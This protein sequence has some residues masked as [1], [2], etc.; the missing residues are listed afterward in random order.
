MP[1][2]TP[3]DYRPL[4][5]P[6]TRELAFATLRKAFERR[7]E[8]SHLRHV[9]PPVAVRASGE[10]GEVAFACCGVDGML[11][12]PSDLEQWKRSRMEAY[13][14]GA[15]YGL[16]TYTIL[17]DTTACPDNVEGP[18]SDRWHCIRSI[19][20]EQENSATLTESMR[21]I[22][23]AVLDAQKEIFKQFPHIPATLP[24]E[25]H[26]VSASGIDSLAHEVRAYGAVSVLDP[27][28]LAAD[29]YLW[30]EI[31]GRE[32]HFAE[33][34]VGK[35]ALSGWISPSRV[36]LRVLHLCAVDELFPIGI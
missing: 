7:L 31:L 29:M 20:P 30:S 25:F 1:L 21:R 9:A 5:L 12:L 17:I 11:A 3:D 36:A 13:G 14:I 35:N 28:G 24:A 16:Y 4:L 34:A 33:I 18:V 19:E 8:A 15:G 32:I 22:Y 2:I 23:D 26:S 10:P 27:F 6:E